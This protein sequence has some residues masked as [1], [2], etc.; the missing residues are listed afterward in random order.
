[1][2][3]D[4]LPSY[5]QMDLNRLP[6]HFGN[7][8]YGD[9]IDE[10]P[11]YRTLDPAVAGAAAPVHPY[12]RINPYLAPPGPTISADSLKALKS[13]KGFSLKSPLPSH[14]TMT[15]FSDHDAKAYS[16][17]R[18]GHTSQDLVLPDSES[19]FAWD[20]S[21]FINA[22][23]DSISFWPGNKPQDRPTNSKVDPDEDS[24]SVVSCTSRCGIGCPSQCGDTSPG[25]C[26]DDDT[27][28]EAREG[29][30]DLCLD[31]TCENAATPCTDEN[32]S[33]LAKQDHFPNEAMSDGDK[34]AAAALASI[35]DT[36][37]A[38]NLQ[39]GFQPFHSNYNFESPSGFPESTCSHA[40]PHGN[41]GT[42]TGDDSLGQF[43]EYL[44]QE[45]PLA[46]HILQYHD[47]RNTVEHVR[48]CM[49]DHPDLAI[50]KCTLPRAVNSDF[51]SHGFSHNLEGHTCGFEVNTIDQ[52]ANH[53][54]E[55]HWQMQMLNSDL[56]G[57]PQTTQV[58]DRF[59]L[60]PS[61]SSISSYSFDTAS[62]SGPRLSPSDISLQNI[63]ALSSIAPSPTSRA[64]TPLAP[65]EELSIEAKSTI[66]APIS[67][68]VADAETATDCICQWKMAGDKICGMR[69]KDAN[70]LHTHTKNDHLKDMTR[71]RPGFCC[72]WHGCTRTNVFG[73]KSKLERHIQT[74][75]G[76]KPVKCSVCGLQLSAKQSLDQHM[77][78]HTGEKPWKCK[79][80]GCTHAFKQ[81]SALTMHERT[82]T[83]YK[84]LVCDICGKSFGESSNLSKH[85][86]THNNRG[87]HVCIICNKDFHRLDQ[88]R[89]HM[90]SNHK[91]K[92]EEAEIIAKGNQLRLEQKAPMKQPV[93]SPILFENQ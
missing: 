23:P 31:E 28:N 53:L 17:E 46:T 82:H 66:I 59:S 19:A 39:G 11:Q 78:T 86:R 90:H 69:F 50:P 92:P 29:S 52:F 48:P 36:Q 21:Y 7:D 93:Q 40:L 63:S 22:I 44:H 54:F 58:E 75:T 26:C 9:F 89:R 33:V 51:L 25:V 8:P 87:S 6:Y 61:R 83:G 49:A 79:F 38:L 56:F 72:Q 34:E 41:L 16:Q 20:N 77:R 71:Q 15:A 55:D 60:V 13:P 27:C 18:Y 80:P 85:R 3:N 81:Q 32:C 30:Q 70:D 37:P 74:H 43:W 5:P 76:Y 84:P 67:A 14:S 73:Q 42:A 24:A 68:T 10:N 88:L 45:N 91:C 47:P 35:G 2:D 64:T 4:H 62:T 1:M 65:P 57:L 12:Y